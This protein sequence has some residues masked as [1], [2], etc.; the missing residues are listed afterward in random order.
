M[1]KL[2]VA[3]QTCNHVTCYVPQ[4]LS[5]PA[6][7]CEAEAKRGTPI[8]LSER[9]S[10][11]MGHLKA[12]ASKSASQT[13]S[14]FMAEAPELGCGRCHAKNTHLAK[15]AAREP[16]ASCSASQ[17]EPWVAPDHCFVLCREHPPFQTPLPLRR[18][19]NL[20]CVLPIPEK[21][22]EAPIPHLRES[23]SRVQEAAKRPPTNS[24][25]RRLARPHPARADSAKFVEPKC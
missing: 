10:R 24:P 25:A 4:Q 2:G 14:R 6:R 9:T 1:P 13:L 8:T 7:P 3:G 12:K 5:N 18:E 20:G 17:E 15:A 23:R 19:G 16:H 21:T 11:N 22:L